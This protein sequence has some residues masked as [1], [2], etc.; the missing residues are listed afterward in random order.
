[1]AVN[2]G[3]RA[4]QKVEGTTTIGPFG[5]DRNPFV[6][7]ENV[8]SASIHQHATSGNDVLFGIRMT[9][10]R[11]GGSDPVLVRMKGLMDYLRITE[12]MYHPEGDTDAEWIEL[13]NTGSLPLDL[14]GVRFVEG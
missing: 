11:P 1:G 8:I 7:G 4:N 13:T 14:G 2:H 12:I 3:T 6:E 9:A 10:D 5:D